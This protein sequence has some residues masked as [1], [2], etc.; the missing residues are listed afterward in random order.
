MSE[1]QTTPERLSAKTYLVL[2]ALLWLVC[3]AQYVVVKLWIGHIQGITFFFFAL[4]IGFT[5]ICAFDYL[6]DRIG[7]E[8]AGPADEDAAAE[9]ES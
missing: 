5:L 2:N 1:D 6:F 9:S 7:G 3:V 4:A 8:D